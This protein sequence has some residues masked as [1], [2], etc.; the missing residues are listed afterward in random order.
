MMMAVFSAGRCWIVLVVVFVLVCGTVGAD[1]SGAVDGSS[2]G[3][4]VAAV[5]GFDDVGG[6]GVHAP[7]V[8]ALEA[9][10]VFEGTGCGDGLF[11]PGEPILRWVMAVWLVRVLDEEPA[12]GGETRFADVDAGEWWA[13]YLETLAD[14]G[15]TAGCAT[16]PLRFC[17]QEAVTRAQMASFLVRA[18]SLEAAGSAGF[19]DT[20]G[21]THEANIDALAG[22]RVTA[23]CATGPL[24][25]CPAKA[26][27]RAQMAT[28]LARATGLVP[29]PGTED[30]GDPVTVSPDDE[31]VA[32]FD[33][34]TTPPLSDLDLDRLADAVATLDETVECP[35]VVAPDSLDDVAEVVRID[36]GCLIVEYEPLRGRTVAEVREALS[37]DPTVH[38]VGVPPPDVY[39]DQTPDKLVDQQWHLTSVNAEG[40]WNRTWPT[41]AEVTV[42]VIDEGVDATH[43]D[44]AGQVLTIGDAC[45]RVPNGG[46]GTHMAGIIAAARGNEGPLVGIAPEARILPIKFHYPSQFSNLGGKQVAW[47]PDCHNLV[48]TVTAAT[49]IAVNA[50]VEVINMSFGGS[51]REI[52]GGQDTLELA[53]RAAIMHDIVVVNSAGNKGLKGSPRQFPSAYPGVIAV[54]ATDPNNRRGAYSTANRDVDIAAPGGGGT[55]GG[56]ILSA[57][58]DNATLREEERCGYKDDEGQ[59]T[60]PGP[61]RTR[62]C[63]GGGTSAAAAVVS[64]VVA[65]MKAHYPDASVN[66]IQYAL[67]STALN[68]GFSSSNFRYDYGH[69]FVNPLAAIGALDGLE[70]GKHEYTDVSAGQSHTCGLR[71]NGTIDCWGNNDYGQTNVPERIFKKLD[72]GANHTCGVRLE[73]GAIKCWG[74]DNESQTG[75]QAKGTPFIP[76]G[77]YTDV[78]AGQFHTCGLRTDNTITCWGAV[79]QD[80]GQTTPPAGKFYAVSAGRF[81]TC[82]IQR[83]ATRGITDG[84]GAVKCWGDNT[85]YQISK[86]PTGK[87][88]DVSAGGY[89]TCGR[90]PELTIECWG[91]TAHG[92]VDDIPPGEF[93]SV[94][95]GWFHT[96][97]IQ[98]T[99][100]KA[101][102]GPVK[103]WGNNKLEQTDAPSDD[104]FT[105]ITAGN[106]H[107]CGIL[108]SETKP[109]TLNVPDHPT[110][111]YDRPIRSYGTIKCWG[112][113]T[114]KQT[115]APAPGKSTIATATATATATAPITHSNAISAAWFH[116]CA[117]RTDSTVD[118]WGF[119]L[120]GQA[121]PPAGGFTAVS[122]GPSNTCGLRAD[123]TVEC[124]G[125]D[126]WG[127]ASPPAGTFTAVSAGDGH[128]CG[129]K[130]RR[131]S[132]VLGRGSGGA[133]FG[134]AGGF[135]GY[136]RVWRCDV[137]VEG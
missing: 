4:G 112:N 121:T 137:W 5:A 26:V 58:P 40:L 18:F 72:T 74:A 22:G 23:G 124:W 8:E 123:G 32:G 92:L 33:P 73:D 107:T 75:I 106:F 111:T 16:G 14:L 86:T 88:I 119:D 70:L 51:F 9:G 10:G 105:A 83:P 25:Y 114:D 116:T 67:Y 56:L 39:P 21:N 17:P 122:A 62:T 55:V 71:T 118:C 76:L 50:G 20:A 110:L 81:H 65:H 69:G 101:I 97:G 99:T 130:A 48:P 12:E 30:G 134:P 127:Q 103:C 135:H 87:F 45:H 66:D 91:S 13:P 59:S 2:D 35:P 95:A 36:G 93:R 96:C 104:N 54:A 129:A 38:A 60:F 31:V 52:T 85:Y 1:P 82:G 41:D 29:L 128:T 11:C 68:S 53:I 49:M 24:R 100:A 115:D 126:H 113:N 61:D 47:D 109:L 34:L 43:P 46:H 108:D 3:S 6:G 84:G 37:V 42:A 15:V 7:A 94:S 131:Y 98:Q 57:W 28:F 78:A 64:G 136:R 102:S 90:R 125:S 79:G 120:W 117:I 133:G 27:T 132:R 19:V 89:H 44:L 77:P 80:K 63:R